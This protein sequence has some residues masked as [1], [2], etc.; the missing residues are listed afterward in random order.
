MCALWGGWRHRHDGP[1]REEHHHPTMEHNSYLM[2]HG[3]AARI[4]NFSTQATPHDS[5][6]TNFS[7]TDP[8]DP[9]TSTISTT[10]PPPTQPFIHR[11][12]MTPQ[13]TGRAPIPERGGD[14]LTI[15]YVCTHIYICIYIYI[16]FYRYLSL[17]L[18]IY[19]YIHTYI[20]IY[21]YTYIHT[22]THTIPQHLPKRL[23]QAQSLHSAKGGAVET[24]CSDLYA[25]IY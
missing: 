19:I 24:G 22:S 6:D 18:Y 12:T 14:T 8:T 23:K 16:Y 15:I 3:H 25:V 2:Y 11:A 17:S 20:Y 1:N 21:I 13:R 9:T 10:V 4:N 5:H 7:T